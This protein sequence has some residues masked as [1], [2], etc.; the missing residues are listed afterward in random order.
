[1]VGTEDRM[2]DIDKKINRERMK[3]ALT[4]QRARSG[5]KFRNPKEVSG[6]YA[7][8]SQTDTLRQKNRVRKSPFA[9]G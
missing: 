1:M 5:Y 6:R 2:K 9:G 3:R 7:Q 8:A 4:A